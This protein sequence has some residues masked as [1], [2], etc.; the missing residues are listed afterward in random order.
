MRK[1]AIL[2]AIVILGSCSGN[3]GPAPS[4]QD[5]ACAILDQRRGWHQD[6]LAAEL[7]WGIPVHVIMATIWKES[8]YR[9][10]ARPP[11]NFFLGSIPMGR[12]SSAYGYSQALDGTW[13]WYQEQTGNRRGDRDDFDDATDFIGWYHNR[14]SE[15][16]GIA[17][18]DAYSLYLA[19]HEGHSGYQRGSY[20]S[21]AWLIGVAREVEAM[22]RRYEAQL[23]FCR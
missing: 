19:Y 16:N 11:R 8:S 6:L 1:L 18:D 22:A 9:P 12:R 3:G 2:L 7:K 10:R 13:D 14:S 15:V 5:D 4:N 20:N 23:P 17:T 21:K